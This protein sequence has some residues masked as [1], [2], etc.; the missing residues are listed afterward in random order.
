MVR[1]LL[2]T[3]AVAAVAIAPSF[4]GRGGGE[5][6]DVTPHFLRY[7]IDKTWDGQP[8]RGEKLKMWTLDSH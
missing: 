2:F 8:V 7:N 1:L 3:L 5:R 4:G 6:P